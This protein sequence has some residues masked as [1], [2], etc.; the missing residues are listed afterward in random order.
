M[1]GSYGYIFSYKK[2]IEKSLLE[3]ARLDGKN[4]LFRRL[5]RD[6]IPVSLVAVLIY[7]NQKSFYKKMHVRNLSY[8]SSSDLSNPT[9]P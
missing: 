2:E 5:E 1:K 9:K 6:S 8:F 7:C 4:L 3:V